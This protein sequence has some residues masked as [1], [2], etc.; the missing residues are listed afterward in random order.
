MRRGGGP[1]PGSVVRARRSRRSRSRAR[2]SRRRR[3]DAPRAAPVPRAAARPANDLRFLDPV[4][5]RLDVPDPGAR[6]GGE[7]ARGGARRGSVL[8]LRSPRRAPRFLPRGARRRLDRRRRGAFGRRDAAP[9]PSPPRSLR[10]RRRARR[11]RRRRARVSSALVSAR[12]LPGRVLLRGGAAAAGGGSFFATAGVAR[13]APR[14]GRRGEAAFQAFEAF[15]ASRLRLRPRRGGFGRVRRRLRAEFRARGGGGRRRARRVGGA[16]LGARAG[17]HEGPRESRRQAPGRV[18]DECFGRRGRG[19]GVVERGLLLGGLLL[20]VSSRASG[21]AAGWAGAGGC[22]FGSVFVASSGAWTAAGAGGRRRVRRA[23]GRPS[24]AT[25]VALVQARGARA[26]PRGT[27]RRRTGGGG[28]GWT[29]TR[30]DGRDVIVYF[31]KY[32]SSL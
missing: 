21:S 5:R 17:G 28:T 16:V 22:R 7:G 12:P 13:W 14:T 8:F 6:R 29:T 19:R 1:G 11:R 32:Y 27:S 30:G 24:A 9:P 31:R 2:R 20:R 18:V 23:R 25:R 4:R 26:T 3:G 10:P 15:E